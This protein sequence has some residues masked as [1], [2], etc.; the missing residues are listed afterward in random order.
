M[1]ELGRWD[2]LGRHSGKSCRKKV[3]VAI[4]SMPLRKSS[5][6][7]FF[8]NGCIDASFQQPVPFRSRVGKLIN[9]SRGKANVVPEMHIVHGMPQIIFRAKPNIQVADFMVYNYNDISKCDEN[10]WLDV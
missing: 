1:E 4:R 6:M 10:K 8:R 2:I 3:N 7:F 5:Y 9:H